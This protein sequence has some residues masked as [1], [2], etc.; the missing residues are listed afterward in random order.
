MSK[1]VSFLDIYKLLPRT[2]CGECG[3]KTCMAFATK[4]ADREV[5]LDACKPLFRPE[6]RELLERLRDLTR[7]PVKEVVVGVGDR[8]VRLGGKTVM[9]RHELTYRNPTSIAIDVT[10]DM[11]ESEL[12]RRVKAI[13]AFSIGRIGQELR[14][15]MIAVRCVSRDPDRFRRT[16]RA[17]ASNSD[18]P[19]VLCSLDPNVVE[20]GLLAVRDRR[21]LIYAATADNWREMGDLALMYKCPLAVFAPNDLSLLKSLASTFASMGVEDLVL[22]PGTFPGDRLRDTIGNFTALRQAAFMGDV[23]VGYPLMG[24]PL[25]V[26]AQGDEGPEIT[27]WR[28]ACLA[29]ALLARFAD[30]LVMHSMDTWAMLPVIT[31]RQNLYTDPRKPVAVEPGLRTIGSPDEVSPV[32]MTTNFS[33]TYFTVSDDFASAGIDC[34]LLVIDTEGISVQSA[35][36]GRKLT[37]DKVAD[38]IRESG[39]EERVRHRVMIIPGYAARLRGEIE[40]LTGWRVLVGPIDSSQIGPFLKKHWPPK[41]EG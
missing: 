30:L 2:N 6:G 10:D 37:A 27:A 36:A 1:P 33:L 16:V 20:S 29:S 24:V 39:V 12:V 19:L 17:V 15:D 32:M 7:P 31:L 34:Y 22:D 4:L 35:V 3:E 9:Y 40:D 18:M 11:P 38:A 5:D 28:E 13:D 14:L 41:E 21:P 8:A 23:G 25:V 26:W